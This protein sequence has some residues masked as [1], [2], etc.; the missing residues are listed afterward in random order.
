MRSFFAVA[1]MFLSRSLR[2]IS[3]T[4]FPNRV[5]GLVWGF[6][7]KEKKPLNQNTCALV[8]GLNRWFKPEQMFSILPEQIPA[9]KHISGH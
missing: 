1:V 5:R 4:I 8:C 2:D 6:F 9:L 3:G 7:Y